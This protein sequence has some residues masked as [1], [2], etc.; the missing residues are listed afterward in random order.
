MAQFVCSNCGEGA[1]AWIGRCPSCNEWNTFKEFKEPS[2]TGRSK[3]VEP[4]NTTTFKKIKTLEKNRKPTGLFEL[5]RVLGGGIVAGEVILL[6]G[7]PGVGKSTLLLQSLKNLKTLYISGE[8]SAA[9]V[10]DRADRLGITFDQFT[11]SDTLQV[12]AIVKGVDDLKL[13]PDVIVIDSVQTIYSKDVDSAPGSVSQLREASAKLIKLSKQTGIPT[14][15]VG[16]VTKDGDIAGPKTLEHMVDAVLTFEGEK[17]SNFRVLRAQ[18]N[19]FGSTD[20]IGIFEMQGLGLV[21][22]DNPLA[23][24]DEDKELHV[25]GKALVGVM[26]GRRPLF[27]EIQTLAAVSFLPVP[28]RVVKGVDYNKVLLL[29]AVLDRHLKL[30]LNKYDIYINVVGGV[31]IKSPAADLGIVA[32]ILSSVKNISLDPHMMFTGEVGLLGE[33]RKV[34]GQDRIVSEAE[35]LKFTKTFSPLNIKTVVELA[36]KLK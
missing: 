1:A 4:F 18:K 20:E 11:F 10:K 8:E 5:D 16:H 25:P 33:V 28:R 30:S 34:V 31:D 13:A 29:L 32:S 36:D 6:T 26:E 23:F 27:F 22:V 17:I 21:E 35:R 12:E 14:I 9:Q 3:N 2:A 19:R 24:I 7:E 15:I